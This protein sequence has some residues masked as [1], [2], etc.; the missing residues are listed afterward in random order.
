MAYLKKII[1]TA[2]LVISCC[3]VVPAAEAYNGALEDAA[4]TGRAQLEVEPD[5]ALITFSVNGQGQTADAAAAEAAE[6]AAAVKRALLGCGILSDDLEN[7]S[8]VLRPM[9][10]DKGKVTGYQA[11]NTVKVTV[12]NADKVGS[13]I[14]KMAAAG[15][16]RIGNPEFT[17]KNKEL[18]QRRLLS[19]AV[20][21]ARSK[22]EMLAAAGGR[23]LGRMLSVQA[24]TVSDFG[25]VYR[26]MA[27]AKAEA[28]S[29]PTVIEA[30]TI[31]VSA[32]VEAV[33][34]ME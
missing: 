13:V 4:V 2:L 5:M 34:A 30:G 21:D 17:V 12:D 7:V 8:Y 14:D 26:N 28:D 29:V 18:L 27:M 10:N 31:N 22:A 15:A 3:G 11:D 9:Y 16:S 19:E 6:K 33:F 32:S 24:H 1:L 23:K 25:R 20:A